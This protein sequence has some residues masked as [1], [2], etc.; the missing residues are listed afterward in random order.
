MPTLCAEMSLFPDTLLDEEPCN[1]QPWNG[2]ERSWMVIYTKSRQE[3]AL[4]RELLSHEVP[5]YLPTVRQESYRRG[6]LASAHVPLL[7]SYVFLFG[8]EDERVLSLTTNRIS[9]ILPVL[10]QEQLQRDLRQ[11]QNLIVTGAPLTIERRLGPGRR[12]RVRSGPL[13]G[14]EGT[15]VR[16]RGECRLIVSVNFLQQG[17]SVVIE[18][19]ML[20]PID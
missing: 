11:L 20:E 13:R 3:K 6:R 17:A 4:A 5:F 18:D 14:F 10:A 8:T 9:R 2:E 15:V 7:S 19:F 1:L 12:V 16:R